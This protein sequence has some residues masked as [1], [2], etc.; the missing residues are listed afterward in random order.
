[1]PEENRTGNNLIWAVTLIIIV[2][3]LA[4]AVFYSGILGSKPTEEID[5]DIKVPATGR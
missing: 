4:G 3:M 1:M 5:V 2:A